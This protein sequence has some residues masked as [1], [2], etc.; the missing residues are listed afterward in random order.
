MLSCANANYYCSKVNLILFQ[1]II[2]RTRKILFK[3]LHRSIMSKLG[4]RVGLEAYSIVCPYFEKLSTI[5]NKL[6]DYYGY[7]YLYLLNIV[8]EPTIHKNVNFRLIAIS[9]LAILM[10]GLLTESFS[11]FRP[12]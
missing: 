6:Y 3:Y 8:S 4:V 7:L 5:Y 12:K 11:T 1:K 2:T 10:D 9:L